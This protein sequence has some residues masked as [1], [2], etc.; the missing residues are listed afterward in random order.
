[1]IQVFQTDQKT[2]LT[3]EESSEI[4]GGIDLSNK[5]I[6]LTNPT[7]REIELVSRAT[8]VSEE[9][10]KTALDS[11]ERARIEYEDGDILT[12]FDIPTIESEEDYYSYSTMPLA[13]IISKPC[14]ITVCL[15]ESSIIHAF[16]NGRAKSFTTF[17]RTRFLYQILYNTHIKFL[18]YLRQI[19]KASTRIQNELHKSTKNKELIQ[20]LD[21][22]KSL[23]YFSTSLRSNCLVIE[24]LGKVA[25]IKRYEEDLDLLEDAAVEN[26]QA[27][28]MCNI[29]RDILSGTMDAFASVISN[30]L[31]IVMKL[32]TSIT[33][34][35]TVPTLVASFWGM[36]T[37]VPFE[38]K[39]Y[40]FFVAIGISLILAFGAAVLLAKKKMF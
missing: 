2:L 24:K 3:S 36:N 19:D 4:T 6:H 35:L 17:K 40:G 29:Y 22:E 31:N 16:M 13:F 23:V 5:W 25:F 20:L 38:G 12:L 14:V 18:E 39:L 15:K 30:N 8:G 27:I 28:E 9:M 34:I 10:L 11:E 1:M 26:R 21:L 32:L 37:G 33:I 7:D